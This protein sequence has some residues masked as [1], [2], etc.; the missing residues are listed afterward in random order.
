MNDRVVDIIVSGV[1]GVPQF[2]PNPLRPTIDDPAVCQDTTRAILDAVKSKSPSTKKPIVV[3]IS[4]TGISDHGR[5]IPVAMI[6]LYHF[7]LPVPHKDKKEMERLLA[8]ET[9]P[10]SSCIE[11]FVVV[12]PS[13]LTNGPAQ[14][15]KKIRVGVESLERLESPAIGYT[16]SRADVGGWIF[17][18]VLEDRDGGRHTYLNKFVTVTY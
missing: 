4:T 10:G 3:V 2:T 16:I 5:D 18:A 15:A 12:R 9:K 11:G 13:L 14:G 6:P 1:G 7:M 17:E 8:A